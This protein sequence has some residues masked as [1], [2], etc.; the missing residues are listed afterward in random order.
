[1]LRDE[2]GDWGD[3]DAQ[4]SGQVAVGHSSSD[5]NPGQLEETSSGKT[6]AKSTLATKQPS[7]DPDDPDFF[8]DMEPVISLP[9]TVSIDDVTTSKFA[10]LLDDD[11]AGSDGWDED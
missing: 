7:S 11:V 4:D 10:V 8:A 3:W 6:S 5:Q 1:M 2:D 9:Q